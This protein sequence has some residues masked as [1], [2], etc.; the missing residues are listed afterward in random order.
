MD[1]LGLQKLSTREIARRENV[2]EATLFKHFKSKN[3]LLKAV[4]DQFSKFDN[5][6]YKS[7]KLKA[8]NPIDAIIYLIS[9]FV[10]Y[11]DNYPAM[12]SILQ[13]FDVLRFE[14]GLTEKI[15]EI[16]HSRA[17]FIKQLVEEAQHDGDIRDDINSESLS[18]M[19]LGFCRE[20]SLRQRLE[21]HKFSLK[22]R[23]IPTVKITLDSYCQR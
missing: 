23:V 15:N 3:E 22:E 16:F 5:D 14:H 8:L 1:E 13:L 18:D 21:G 4:L 9:S 2:T 11:Y 10:E 12:T 19:L 17:S 6:L 20:T 7:T